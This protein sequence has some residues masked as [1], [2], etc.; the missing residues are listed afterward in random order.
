MLSSLSGFQLSRTEST[1][2]TDFAVD[3]F[4]DG[5]E[6]S[7]PCSTIEELSLPVEGSPLGRSTQSFTAASELDGSQKESDSSSTPLMSPAVRYSS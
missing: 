2:F 1:Y 4:P 6:A 7:M 5:E 3:L